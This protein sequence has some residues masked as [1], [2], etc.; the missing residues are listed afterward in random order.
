MEQTAEL[1]LYPIA[2]DTIPVRAVGNGLY[3]DIPGGLSRRLLLKREQ[4]PGG[5]RLLL[6]CQLNAF[7]KRKPGFAIQYFP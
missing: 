2:A 4:R 3:P 5:L 6:L 7:H 1:R